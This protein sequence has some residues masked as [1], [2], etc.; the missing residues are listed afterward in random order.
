MSI[1]SSPRFF[2]FLDLGFIEV[3]GHSE[4]VRVYQVAGRRAEPGSLRGVVG[5]SSPMVGRDQELEQSDAPVRDGARRPGSSR[6][7]SSASRG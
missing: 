2:D 1:A 7:R 4:P 6:A 3:K 5:L